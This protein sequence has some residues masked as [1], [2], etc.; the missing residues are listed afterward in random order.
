MNYGAGEVDKL[1]YGDKEISGNQMLK[2]GTI[3]A[4]F[5][6]FSDVTNQNLLNVNKDLTNTNGITV[7]LG[8][9]NLDIDNYGAYG[10]Y[11]F[12]PSDYGKE[13]K[14]A[15]ASASSVNGLMSIKKNGNGSYAFY[16]T[17]VTVFTIT[18]MA[19]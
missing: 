8:G 19:M 4:Q 11:T 13:R 6:A 1:M 16:M 18:I 12:V 7:F 15:I 3:L 14:W 2:S 5:K 9:R 17:G 10:K